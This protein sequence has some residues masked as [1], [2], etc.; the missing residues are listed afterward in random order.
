MIPSGRS[1]GAPACL[2]ALSVILAGGGAAAQPAQPAQPAQTTRP[3]GLT[4]E[5][6]NPGQ[7][8]APARR[9]R[10]VDVFS[11]PTR[12]GCTLSE[13]PSLAFDLKRVV[14][15]DE[16]GIL[17]E[18]EKR[19]ALADLLGKR[20]TP[21]QLCEV[22]DRLAA[23]IFRRG[24]LARVNIPAQTIVDGVV[25]FHVFPARIVAVRIDG[26][27]GPVQARIESYLSRLRRRNLFNLDEVQRWLLL[28]NDLPGVQAVASVVHSTAPGAGPGALDLVVTLRRTAIDETGLVANYNARTLGPWSGLVRL[29][30]NSLTSL[31]DQTSIVGYSTLGNNRQ[32]VVQVTE[33]ARLGPSGLF[34]QASFSYGH[35]RP[36]NVLAPLNLTGNSYVGTIEADYPLIRLQRRTLLLAGGMDFVNQDTR[37]ANAQAITDDA[38]RVAWA[39]LS[40]SVSAIDRPWGGSLVSTTADLTVQARK[41]L[42]VLGA[43]RANAVAEKPGADAWVL[44]ADGHAAI[45]IAPQNLRY[46]PVT[47]SAHFLGQWAD[48]PLV[49]YEQ[50]GIGNLTIG[51]GFD[52][53]AASGD[54]IIALGLRAEVGPIR[55]G[56]RLQVSPYVFGDTAH[57]AYLTSTNAIDVH[58]VGGG[59]TFRI[60]YD[61]RG[62]AVRIDAGYACPLDKATP[63]AARNPPELFLVQIIVT[64]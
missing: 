58:S 29:D 42:D 33:S 31:G 19:L 48:R 46:L 40:G 56:R 61:A 37:F 7:Q 26:D 59:L 11:G 60:P 20:I 12:E 28:A 63:I 57:L 35:A 49:G 9:Q 30:L 25:T 23:R 53:G 22:R 13:D 52:P 36:G 10:P 50:Q 6:L 8:V 16:A 45:R 39:R 21:R 3:A 55:I 43:S 2:A 62:N 41:G 1:P 5:Q 18:G 32:E 14:V 34:A 51:R 44:R 4:R 15:Q 38:L 17:S 47:V 24:I 54:E 27:V 64:H